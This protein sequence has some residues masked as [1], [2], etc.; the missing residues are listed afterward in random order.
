MCNT[1]RHGRQLKY[2]RCTIPSQPITWLLI[3]HRSNE[4]AFHEMYI[5]FDLIFFQSSALPWL[6]SVSHHAILTYSCGFPVHE[7]CFT[8]SFVDYSNYLWGLLT[9]VWTLLR[10]LA[11]GLFCLPLWI[12]YLCTKLCMF[13]ETRTSLP[14]IFCLNCLLTCFCWPPIYL[15]SAVC[16]AL[17]FQ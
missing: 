9:C 14:T 3:D 5:R 1:K 12:T 16:S 7:L 17:S 2:P 11:C 4:S 15:I 8:F 10:F 13:P 6:P